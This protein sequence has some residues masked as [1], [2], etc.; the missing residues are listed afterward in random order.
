MSKLYLGSTVLLNMDNYYSKSESYNKSEVDAAVAA[1]DCSDAIAE[2]E[3]GKVDKEEGKSLT[4]NDFTDAL[5]SKLNGLSNYDDTDISTRVS[6]LAASLDALVG[7]SDVTDAIDTFNEIKE[8][9]ADYENTDSLVNLL[10]TTENNV[11]SWVNQ[12]GYVTEASLTLD[13]YLKITDASAIYAKK[14]DVE[15]QI[16]EA[17]AS[18]VVGDGVLG[19]KKCTSAEYALIS[20]KVATTLYVV[21]D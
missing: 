20:P 5:L 10:A 19:I 4:S 3:E 18:L 13:E 6:T 8:F 14:E 15:D 16:E 11:K 7:E 21:T 1:V 17:T 12:Q 9:L 2:L